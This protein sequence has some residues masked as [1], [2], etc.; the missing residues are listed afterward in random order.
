MQSTRVKL[1]PHVFRLALP[2]G[3]TLLATGL[4]LS[5]QSLEAF[6]KS[7][8]PLTAVPGFGFSARA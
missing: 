4:F 5:T 6:Y 8:F 3:L 2:L 1:A 7:P